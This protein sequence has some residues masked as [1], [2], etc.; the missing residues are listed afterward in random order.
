MGWTGA[1]LREAVGALGW[2]EG[3]GML[4][5]GPEG[6]CPPGK[7]AQAA[8]SDT[9][10]PWRVS[11]QRSGRA[12][13]LGDCYCNGVEGGPARRCRLRGSARGGEKPGGDTLH[14]TDSAGSEAGRGVGPTGLGSGPLAPLLPGRPAGLGLE[15]LFP[16]SAPLLPPAAA[17]LPEESLQNIPASRR[18]LPRP[19]P[20]QAMKEGASTRGSARAF[21]LAPATAG[22][23]AHCFPSY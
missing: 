20:W 6:L 4:V 9:A 18:R 12:H 13:G 2:Q 10:E 14:R 15:Q 1:E 17:A 5:L 19:L 22:P 21:V 11:G 3:L 8:S 7:G 23:T 16:P